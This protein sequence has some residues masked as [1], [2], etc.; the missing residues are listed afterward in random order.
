MSACL[1]AGIA[2]NP[3]SALAGRNHLPDSPTRGSASGVGAP[4]VLAASA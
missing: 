1:S 4:P 3:A 2:R